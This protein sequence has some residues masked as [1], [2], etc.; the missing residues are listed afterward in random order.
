MKRKNILQIIL[1]VAIIYCFSSFQIPEPKKFELYFHKITL[2]DSAGKKI[3]K[4][5]KIG[6]N[7]Y[8]KYTYITPKDTQDI[9]VAVDSL[10]AVYIFY[11]NKTYSF[12]L[13]DLNLCNQKNT[14]KTFY[15]DYEYKMCIQLPKKC[16]KGTYFVFVKNFYS[17]IGEDDTFGLTSSAVTPCDYTVRFVGNSNVKEKL[18]RKYKHLKNEY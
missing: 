14:Q 8:K 7:G 16:N 1:F 13:T 5:W 4:D 10:S 12:F 17:G 15:F 2:L 11:K 3:N 18:S 6:V 9:I